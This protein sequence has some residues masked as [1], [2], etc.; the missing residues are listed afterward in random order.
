MA[1]SG[2]AEDQPE[3]VDVAATI[4]IVASVASAGGL[5]FGAAT[6]I[7]ELVGWLIGLAAIV[8][9]WRRASSDYLESRTRP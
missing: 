4:S 2:P 9:L 8:L 3:S 6:K 5:S 1:G 7:Y